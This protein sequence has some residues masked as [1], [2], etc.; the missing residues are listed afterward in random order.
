MQMCCSVVRSDSRRISV[1][2]NNNR[3]SVSSAFDVCIGERVEDVLQCVAVCCS[4]VQCRAASC[5]VSQCNSRN[6][7]VYITINLSSDLD[8]DICVAQ[9]VARVVAV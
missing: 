2:I 9:T 7:S 6:I 5:S 8:I 3:A 4:V 1:H